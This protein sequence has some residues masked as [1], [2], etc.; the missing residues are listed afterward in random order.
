MHNVILLADSKF[1]ADFFLVTINNFLEPV[2]ISGRQWS[3]ISYLK[4]VV[5]W[6]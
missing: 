4:K 6:V 3:I 5:T 2:G 1:N